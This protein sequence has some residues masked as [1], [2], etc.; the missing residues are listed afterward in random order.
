MLLARKNPDL[1]GIMEE[2]IEGRRA[3]AAARGQ[4]KGKGRGRK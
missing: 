2:F 1:Q 4:A 3:E